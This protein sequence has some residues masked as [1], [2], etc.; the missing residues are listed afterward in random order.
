MT[1]LMEESLYPGM[2]NLLQQLQYACYVPADFAQHFSAESVPRVGYDEA[3]LAD[4]R[5]SISTTIAYR[6]GHCATTNGG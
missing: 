4:C 6:R 5:A 1:G 3:N 2:F